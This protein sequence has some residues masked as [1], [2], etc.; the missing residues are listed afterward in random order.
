MAARYALMSEGHPTAA[1]QNDVVIDD[2]CP[3]NHLITGRIDAGGTSQ[4]IAY[5]PYEIAPGDSIHIVFAE[6][7]SGI[8]REKNREVA[9][10]WIQWY[11]A[12]GTPTLHLPDGSTTPDHNLY[13]R[14]WMETGKDSIVQT[15]Q[16][17]LKN[18][19]ANYQIPQPPPPPSTFTVTSGGDRIILEWARNAESDLHFGGYVI[20]RSVGN[21]LGPK[22]VYEKLVEFDKA[23]AIAAGGT[24]NDVTAV[25]GLRYYYYIQSKDDGTQND[26]EPGKPLY[27]SLFWTVTNSYATLQR[28]AGNFLGEFRVVPNPYD[29]RS[30]QFQF[31]NGKLEDRDQIAFYGLPPRCKIKIF[32]ERGDLIWEKNHTKGTGDELWNSETMSAQILVSGVY[33][34]Y[35][36][37]TEDTYALTDI[38]ANKDIYGDDLKVPLA[39]QGDVVFRAGDLMFHKGDSKFRKFVV[40]R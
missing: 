40:I 37:V 23:G 19:E 17:A 5:G 26:I 36:E 14:S 33:I 27:S 3:Q 4:D 39:R 16:R 20:Y 2:D 30:R 32:T 8:S 7:I 6:G 9:S 18:Y 12:T 13:K 15:Y 21:V 11:K 35:I 29:V 38:T 10:N 1:E 31:G 22:T 24:Y 28:P 25:R 34:V